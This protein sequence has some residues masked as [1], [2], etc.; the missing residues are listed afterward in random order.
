MVLC[1]LYES[2]NV[3]KKTRENSRKISE[4]SIFSFPR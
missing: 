4:D 3:Q 1:D 2:Y